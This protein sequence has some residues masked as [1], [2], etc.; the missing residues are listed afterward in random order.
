MIAVVLSVSSKAICIRVC[1][2]MNQRH[3]SATTP[4]A[5]TA[6]INSNSLVGR[7]LADS[8]ASSRKITSSDSIGITS[9]ITRRTRCVCRPAISG[10][11]PISASNIDSA[12]S[13]RYA[14][15]RNGSDSSSAA[16]RSVPSA[17]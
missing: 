8:A 5:T 4:A 14:A 17:G 11:T 9:A 12:L 6:M 16:P 13:L 1:T 2:R 15:I 3:S 10:F 7:M